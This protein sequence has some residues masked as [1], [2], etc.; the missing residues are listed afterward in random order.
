MR[1]RSMMLFGATAALAAAFV[2]VAH[3]G[4]GPIP[5]LGD[6]LDPADGLYRT[7]RS[8]AAP[9]PDALPIDA[10]NEPVTVVRDHRHVPHIFAEND[11]DAIITLGYVTAQDRLFQ[12]D[13]I[14]RVASGRLAE[15]FGQG[16]VSTDQFLRQTGMDWGAR[17]NLQ[18]IREE[19]GIEWDVVQWYVAGVNAYLDKLDPADWPFEFRLLGYAPDRYTPLQVMRVL[20]YM[21]YDLTYGSDDADY[22]L[23]RKELGDEAFEQLYPRHHDLYVPIIPPE[24]QIVPGG[25]ASRRSPSLGSSSSARSGEVTTAARAAWAERRAK[26]RTLSG[27][28]AEG[29]RP[30]KGSNNWAVNSDRSTTGDPILAGDMHL[31]LSLPAIWYEAHLVTPTMNTYGVTVPGAPL[32]VEAF[33]DHIGWAF[34]NTG[35]DQI[36]HLALEVDAA[37]TQYRY[38][39]G[40]RDLE[41]VPDTIQVKDSAPVVDTLYYAHHGPVTFGSRAHDGGA[42]ASRWVA[43]RRSR[44]LRALWEMNHAHDLASFEGALRYW[45]TPMQN[46]LYGGTDGHIA[47]RSTGHL[48]VRRAG[49]GAGLLDGSTDRFD[50]VGRVPFDSLPYARDPAQGFLSSSNQR[51][52]GP[53]YPYYLKWD[54]SDSYRSLRL[55]ELLRDKA[56]HSVDDLK[57]YQADVRAVQP[58]LFV[59]LL[60]AVGELSPRADTLRQMLTQWNGE[61]TTDRPEPLVMDVF[62]NRLRALAWDEPVFRNLPA[63]EDVQLVGLL[64]DNPTSIWLDITATDQR[65]GGDDLLGR[66]L[67]ATVDTLSARHQ[68]SPTAWTWGDHHSVLFRHLTQNRQLEPLW[69]GPYPYPGFEATVSP[70]RGRTATHSASWRVVVDFSTAPPTGYGVYPGGQSGNPFD[71]SLYDGHLDTYLQFEHYRLLNPSDLAAFPPEAVSERVSFAPSASTF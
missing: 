58:D 44:T 14:P 60:E 12:M 63:P 6:L 68:W 64:R 17:R 50:W 28:A 49:H 45:D 2:F 47:I 53:N 3:R 5:P 11:R 36:D 26:Q 48:P 34:T 42:V 43:H 13:F 32:P 41:R 46:I 20:Q 71:P 31:S 24:Q 4:A 62:L 16:S 30:G 59:P 37:R 61:T 66:A 39:G 23:L 1:W 27:T 55:D 65:E 56:S 25:S 67:Q 51:P 15:A 33:N 19:S 35:A 38:E 54:W 9:S 10:L 18:A 40:W 52:T 21:T 8:T 29:Y 57:Q 7:A 69:R 22:A 70:A